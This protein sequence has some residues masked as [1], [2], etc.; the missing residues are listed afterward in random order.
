LAVLLILPSQVSALYLTEMVSAFKVPDGGIKV[1]G[2][3]DAIW[4]AVYAVGAS[5]RIS[6]DDYRRI[7]L[8]GADSLRNNPDPSKYYQAPK[9]G[10]VM[11]LAAFDNTALYFFFL[12]A[13]NSVFNPSSLCTVANLW[14]ADAPDV[15]VD[16]TP[17]SPDNYTAFFNKDG[18]GLVYGTSPKT[19][20]L[21]MPIYSKDTPRLYYRDRTTP[22]DR[23]QIPASIPNGVVAVAAQ[24]P[25]SA[26]TY[27]VEMKIPFWTGKASD[28]AAGKSMFISWGYNH[29]PDNV[30]STCDSV[31]IAYRWAKHFKT[32]AAAD[33][34]PPGWRA[35]D[36]THFDPTRSWDGWG[37]LNLNSH[38]V[39]GSNCKFSDT[40][41]W[42]VGIWVSGCQVTTSNFKSFPSK[43]AKVPGFW[44]A[45][46]SDGNPMSRD[47]RGRLRQSQ[48]WVPL[49]PWT[50]GTERSGRSFAP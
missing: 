46:E 25:K 5:S 1:D 35:G 47:I 11:M 36:S 24:S 33:P 42:D 18:T 31:P 49:F 14:A 15:F 3:P 23:F 48:A 38:F 7:V 27:G 30:T 22:P 41:S 34:K 45:P 19:V 8:L 6:F 20:Q 39:D 43:G 17:W 26:L 13:E 12:V 9:T 32:Y 29:Y 37:Q 4:K 2:K 44:S 10:S 28:F 50:A 16:P 21:A 40:A